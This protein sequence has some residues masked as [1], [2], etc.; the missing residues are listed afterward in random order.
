M[1]EQ[2]IKDLTDFYNQLVDTEQKFRGLDEEYKLF[3]CSGNYVRDV[4]TT[5]FVRMKNT[6]KVFMFNSLFD[7]EGNAARFERLMKELEE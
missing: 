6:K 7:E 2:V 1:R 3:E 4:A 5:I